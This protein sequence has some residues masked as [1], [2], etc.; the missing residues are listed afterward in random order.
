LSRLITLVLSAVLSC[1]CGGASRDAARPRTN[2]PAP[3]PS[4]QPTPDSP[5]EPPSAKGSGKF[6]QY[7]FTF[8]RNGHDAEARFRPTPLPRTDSA[9]VA[10][11]RVVI[12]EA[13]G[14]KMEGF[15]R[16]VRWIYEGEEVQAIKLG[17]RS[18]DYVFWPVKEET[19]E[20]RRM[21]FWRVTKN[22]VR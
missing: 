9:V 12:Q 21:L 19:K 1:A 8:E 15:P 10:A 20:V 2:A 18:Y 16:P 4:A 6:N 22:T 5:P 14:E 11:A 3:S 7:A 13:Y 17:G